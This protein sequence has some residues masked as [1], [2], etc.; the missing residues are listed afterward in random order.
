MNKWLGLV[1][2]VVAACGGD[3]GGANNNNNNGSGSQGVCGDGALASNEMCDD[4]NTLSGDGCA[5]N[6]QIENNGSGN[7]SGSGSGSGNG[8]G[9]G[10]GSGSG[11]GGG[12]NANATCANPNEL[13]LEDVGGFLEGIAEGDTSTST[14]QVAEAACDGAMSGAAK[15]HVWKFTLTE[16]SDVAIYT[17]DTMTWNAGIRLMTTACDLSTQ[18]A[19]YATVDGCADSAAAEEMEQ[20]YYVGLPAGTYYVVIDGKTATDDGAYAFAVDA[21]ATWCGDGEVDVPD[22]SREFCDDGN[23][24]NGDG[25]NARC[26]I[27]A[28]YT[29]NNDNDPSVCTADNSGGGTA[30]APAAGDLKIN[31]F[32]AGDDTSDSNCDNSTN[33]NEDEFIELINT[34]TT[35]TLDLTG[36]TISDSSMLRHTFTPMTV[37][38]GKAV[39]VWGGG[40]PACPG[41]GPA[42]WQKASTGQLG[43]QDSGGDTMIVKLG[44]TTI[45]QYAYTTITKNKSLNLNPD[46]T[47][48]TY[49]THDTIT[50]HVGN[51]SPGKKVDG[52]AF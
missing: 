12:G 9:S 36:V 15:D 47:G 27:E 30:V 41:V 24:M 35:K 16:T 44:T 8:N 20:L 48:T 31:E 1:L 45:T 17:D 18:V 37:A 21:Y 49:A 38:P 13:M 5:S 7:G 19:E 10:S 32:L 39:V 26:E 43:L 28:G 23:T 46:I 52:T 4:G 11:S 51:W 29:C 14:D 34:S 33:Q 2:V 40:A 6:C 50:G 25:C 22:L 42:M 3:D